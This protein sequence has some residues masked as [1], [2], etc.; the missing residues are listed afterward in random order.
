MLRTLRSPLALSLSLSHTSPPPLLC[1][2][3]RRARTADGGGARGRSRARLFAEAS[4]TVGTLAAAAAQA[5][6]LAGTFTDELGSR[7]GRPPS[8]SPTR[9]P[10]TALVRALSP[11]PSWVGEEP[12]YP[13]EEAELEAELRATAGAAGASA[14]AVRGTARERALAPLA[15]QWRHGRS[16]P[17]ILSPEA[18]MVVPAH[19]AAAAAAAS[20]SAAAAAAAA[21]PPAGSGLAAARYP[22]SRGGGGSGR[23]SRRAAAVAARHAAEVARLGLVV[24]GTPAMVK[25][26]V[27]TISSSATH[28]REHDNHVAHGPPWAPMAHARRRWKPSRQQPTLSHETKPLP[29]YDRSL[30]V[31]GRR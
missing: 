7:A 15:P 27:A 24:K 4:G 11:E 2:P 14:R 22:T 12:R 26:A 31:R 19:A 30:G 1:S 3:E 16:T 23:S 17:L 6:T 9:Q 13:E 10:T 8:R 21:P 18:S 28:T 29:R 5:A 20:A 25:R